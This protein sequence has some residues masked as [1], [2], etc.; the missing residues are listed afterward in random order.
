M[1]MASIKLN[2]SR[3][4]GTPDEIEDG[5]HVTAEPSFLCI[6]VFW[7]FLRLARGGKQGCKLNF[8]PLPMSSC[9]LCRQLINGK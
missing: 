6:T 8:R 9:L 7:A 2:A 3:Q 5:H 1:I 4:R